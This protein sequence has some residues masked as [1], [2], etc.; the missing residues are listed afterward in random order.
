VLD[1]QYGGRKD[2][3]RRRS[4]S[5]P[6]PASLLWSTHPWQKSLQRENVPRQRSVN[7]FDALV[8]VAS[9]PALLSLWLRTTVNKAHA[10]NAAEA[11]DCLPH[12]DAIVAFC[13][14]PDVFV[15]WHAHN[16][17]QSLVTQD[18]AAA[19]NY[20]QLSNGAQWV[21]CIPGDEMEEAA[22]STRL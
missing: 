5:D 20:E 9:Q 14:P 7:S 15:W 13:V 8:A 11:H 4:D 22:V 2:Q 1:L 21:L 19:Q 17:V 16:S 10:L 18:E 6:E 3:Q 12:I